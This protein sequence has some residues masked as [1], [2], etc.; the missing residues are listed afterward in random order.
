MGKHQWSFAGIVSDCTT[1]E[2]ALLRLLKLEFLCLFSFGE[3][4]IL[5][6]TKM[7]QE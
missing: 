6:A 7:P 1:M 2:K 4:K 5:D 3:Q